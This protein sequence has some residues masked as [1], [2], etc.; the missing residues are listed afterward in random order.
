MKRISWIL[1]LLTALSLS[2]LAGCDGDVE[3]DEAQ[4]SQLLKADRAE[5]FFSSAPQQGFEMSWSTF[6]RVGFYDD[7]EIAYPII[8]AV[9]PRGVYRGCTENQ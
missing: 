8:S 9:Y 5:R 4:A 7:T 1:V 3:T 6:S 2:A